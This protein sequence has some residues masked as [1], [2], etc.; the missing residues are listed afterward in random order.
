[1]NTYEFISFSSKAIF[2]H[3][4]GIISRSI[5]R[6]FE[7][8]KHKCRSRLDLSNITVDSKIPI[9]IPIPRI[10]EIIPF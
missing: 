1:M 9:F 10:L 3:Q 7:S 4:N 6:I 5:G 2:C 8:N